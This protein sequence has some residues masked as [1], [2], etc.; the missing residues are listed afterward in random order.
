MIV[1]VV[2]RIGINVIL[3]LEKK[4]TGKKLRMQVNHREFFLALEYSNAATV[5][6]QI[7]QLGNDVQNVRKPILC[8]AITKIKR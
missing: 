3:R 5:N 6:R 4:N 7:D 8:H 1:I 2:W